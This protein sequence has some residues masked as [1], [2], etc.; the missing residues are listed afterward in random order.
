M[1]R[2]EFIDWLESVGAIYYANDENDATDAV[3][4]FGKKEFEL[5]KKF[6][7][8]YAKLYL[9]YLRVS[10]FGERGNSLYTRDNGWCEWM[11]PENVKDICVKLSK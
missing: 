6:P 8:K 10:H 3:Y 9:P 5:K 4:I 11:S 7:R 2:S 1:T